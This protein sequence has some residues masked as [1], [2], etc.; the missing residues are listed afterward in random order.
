LLEDA[1]EVNLVGPVRDRVRTLLRIRVNRDLPGVGSRPGIG[2]RVFRGDLRM[3]VQAGMSDGL[4]RWLVGEGWRE[5]TFR[6]D[7]RRYRDIPSTYVT[8]LIDCSSDQRGRI[9]DAA[10]ANAVLRPVLDRRGTWANT[11]GR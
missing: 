3:T 7:R 9:L 6:P 11:N 8:Q 4:W 5:I 10:I 2:A 1:A